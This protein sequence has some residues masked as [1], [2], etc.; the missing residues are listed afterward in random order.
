MTHPLDA[1]FEILSPEESITR[2]SEELAE[3]QRMGVG[4]IWL[5]EPT[6]QLDVGYANGQ[7]SPGSVFE[8]PGSSSLVSFAQIAALAD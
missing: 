5:I 8:P 7:L 1:V 4:G 3:D 6:N 2:R